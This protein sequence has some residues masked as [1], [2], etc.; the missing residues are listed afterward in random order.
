[1]DMKHNM[2]RFVRFVPGL[3]VGLGL[4]T[5]C[6]KPTQDDFRSEGGMAPDP[7]GVIEGTVVYIGPKPTC[8]YKKGKASRVKGRVVLTMFQFDNPPPPEG[9]ATTALNLL[10]IAGENVF[11]LED[12]LA[13][14]ETADPSKVIM[15]NVAFRWPQIELT[16]APQAFQ[17]RG[18]YDYD[19]DMNPFFS[20]TNLPTSGDIA[21]AAIANL[22][23]PSQGFLKIEMPARD[24]ARDGYL[25]SGVTV[26]LANYVWA[27]RPAFKLASGHWNLSAESVLPV[28]VDAATFGPDTKRTLKNAWEQTCAT[29]GKADCGFALESLSEAEDGPK[30]SAA[31]VGLD[32]DPLRY[33][34]MVQPVDIKTVVEGGPDLPKPDGIPDPHPLLGAT[35]PVPYTLPAVILQRRA[36]SVEQGKL[37]AQAGVPGV[38]LLGASLPHEIETKQVFLDKMNMAVPSIAVVDLD[39]SNPACRVPYLP[40]GSSISSYEERMSVCEELP[41][42]VYGVNVLHG[43]SGGKPSD[44]DESVSDNGRVIQGGGL[45]GQAWTLPNQLSDP[46]QV[47]NKNV[48]AHQ[49]TDALFVV[50]DPNPDVKGDC[51]RGLEPALNVTRDIKYKKVCGAE[52]SPFSESEGR[53]GTPA[54]IDG[55][56]CLLDACCEGVRHLCGVPLCEVVDVRGLS[57]R[58]SPTRVTTKEIKGI[59]RGIPDCVPFAVPALCCPGAGPIE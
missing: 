22:Q 14:A 10:A 38:M 37:E 49:G 11:T 51:K 16:G 50:H 5:G 9:T 21:G 3:L 57:V 17:I 54:G 25:K 35:L 15:R 24:K 30:L 28:A 45:A 43:I 53:Y 40:P 36:Q 31:G 6:G 26:A 34:F 42:G 44:A 13:E 41:T 23:D 8:E 2:L 4:A 59:E 20:V 1:M 47:G 39:P 7:A 52:E 19:E 55:T 32:W 48:L 27:E 46:A 12:C 58:G 18:F 56:S 33:A 29:P